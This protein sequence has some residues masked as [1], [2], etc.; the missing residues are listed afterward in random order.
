MD[1][2]Q[3]LGHVTPCWEGA[4]ALQAHSSQV[5]AICRTIGLECWEQTFLPFSDNGTVTGDIVGISTAC[6][7]NSRCSLIKIIF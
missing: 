6:R 1:V 4:I 7:D 2:E 5:P 3:H